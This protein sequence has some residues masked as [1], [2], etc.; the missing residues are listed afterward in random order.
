MSGVR[1]PK[2]EEG[3]GE[4]NDQKPETNNQKPAINEQINTKF[5]RESRERKRY[6][7]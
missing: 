6:F 2:T 5:R 7:P 1:S 4:T 3:V